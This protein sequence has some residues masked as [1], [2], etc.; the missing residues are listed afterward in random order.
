[1]PDCYGSHP[2]NTRFALALSILAASF[3]VSAEQGSW[4]SSGPYG[5]DVYRLIV[6]PSVPGRMYAS[7]RGGFFRKAAANQPWQQVS[8]GLLAAPSIDGPLVL[9][10]EGNENL[11]AFDTARRLYRSE[12][13]TDPYAPAGQQTRLVWTP[14][15]F[16]LPEQFA[17][18]EMVE[19]STINGHLYL[20]VSYRV[21]TPTATGASLLWRST[22]RGATFAPAPNLPADRLVRA[23]AVD[24]ANPDHVLAGLQSYALAAPGPAEPSI[25]ESTDG[26]ASFAASYAGIP[27]STTF[28]PMVYDLAFGPGGRAFAVIQSKIHV[29]DLNGASGA[30]QETT[31]ALNNAG[32]NS[33]VIRYCARGEYLVPHPT[34]ADVVYSIGSGINRWTIPTGVA[35]PPIAAT[36][37][38]VN[39]ELTANPTLVGESGINV[40]KPLLSQVCMFSPSS[41]YPGT[42]G[43]HLLAATLGAGLMRTASV[44]NETWSRGTINVGLGGVNIRAVAFNPADTSNVLAGLGDNFYGSPGLFGSIDNGA[45]W[46]EDANV[47]LKASN[48][49]F[50]GFDPTTTGSGPAGTLAYA[51][52]RTPASP[53]FLNDAGYRSA[54]IFKGAAG[55]TSWTS[56]SG[57]L[58]TQGNRDYVRTVRWIALDPR[59][60]GAMPFP[61]AG[62]PCPT[63]V[64]GG[65]K[66]LYATADG[67][68][69]STDSDPAFPG[70]Y[71]DE[72]T[73]RLTR[74][75]DGGQTYVALDTV[76][77]GWPRSLYVTTDT[78]EKMYQQ[79]TPY[80]TMIDPDNSQRLFVPTFTT[81]ADFD[82]NDAYS[83]DIES[84]VYFSADGGATWTTRNNGLPKQPGWTNLTQD[85]LS[86]VMHPFTAQIMW[87]TT[88]GFDRDT[89]A[90]IEGGV[91]RTVD[92]GAN[93][94]RVSTGLP[95][96]VDIRALI[97]DPEDADLQ[98]LTPDNLTLYAA[99]GGTTVEPGGVFRS[100]DGGLNWRSISVGLPA[101][102]A[103]A[104]AVDPADRRR[105]LAGTDFGVWEITQLTDSDGDGIPNAVENQPNG[106][107]G[108][109]DGTPDSAQ[110]DVGT[111][112]V[113]IR[114]PQGG[115]ANSPTTSDVIQ[116]LSTSTVPGGCEQTEDVQSIPS[117]NFGQ[118]LVGAGNRRFFYPRNL[119][120]IQVN[121]CA[122][123]VVDIT[124]HGADFVNEYGWSFRFFGPQVPG[125]DTTVGWKPFATRAELLTPTVN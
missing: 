65:L 83:P 57:N 105:L 25:W 41:G 66:R 27:A 101:A 94:I 44:A 122:H 48:V 96:R 69:T 58:P 9:D 72:F 18:Y 102:S 107:D 32:S 80:L 30:W 33:G 118:D 98:N 121:D 28:N 106:G 50:I 76:V 63:G 22:D 43:S 54:G 39:Q 37:V 14:T 35:T 100:D 77:A 53:P 45:T 4:S 40:G 60:C 1:M 23:I 8:E 82:L 73:H 47:G 11:Y 67:Y 49:R 71:V 29:N 51:A 93:W 112:G 119:W 16:V 111:I 10:R 62:P 95:P 97:L 109:F 88:I 108:N 115:D 92:G 124:Y 104:L 52:G 6:D 89:S 55:G 64:I 91:Y 56:L 17:P 123:A 75:D 81:I 120:R 2:M 113:S 20:A 15:G 99:S 61:S 86:S 19:S 116:A 3:I 117:I 70:L 5:G 85:I 79:L 34:N 13:I 26:G 78:E 7:A 87:V 36:M 42:A 31:G 74:S 59:S 125:D 68:I 114:S 38:E 103:T 110:R 84:G 46:T 90:L 12:T 24:P 21:Q